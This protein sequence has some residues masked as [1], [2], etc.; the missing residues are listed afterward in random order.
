MDWIINLVIYYAVAV[1]LWPEKRWRP[2]HII[3]A[4]PTFYLGLVALAFI[5]VPILRP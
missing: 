5:V 4:V 2:V 1:Y 3:W